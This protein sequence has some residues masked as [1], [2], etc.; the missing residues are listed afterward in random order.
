MTDLRRDFLRAV[1]EG[2]I[3]TVSDMLLKNLDPSFT[4]SDIEEGNVSHLYAAVGNNETEIVSLLLEHSANVNIENESGD[5]PLFLAL[6][7]DIDDEIL[8]LLL[9]YGAD[10]NHRNNAGHNALHKL[11]ED[12]TLIDEEV[13]VSKVNRLIAVINADEC[14]SVNAHGK[15]FLHFVDTIYKHEDATGIVS[16]RT[17]CRCHCSDFIQGLIAKGLSVNTKD[18]FGLTPLHSAIM[19]CCFEGVGTLLQN[20]AII[21]SDTSN[22]FLHY[23]NPLLPGFDQTLELLLS[24]GCDINERNARKETAL[25]AVLTTNTTSTRP[26]TILLQNGADVHAKDSLGETPLH[27]SVMSGTDD[28]LEPEIKNQ[29]EQESKR[30]DKLDKD[31]CCTET[32]R[33][34]VDKG[35]DVNNKNAFGLTALHYGVETRGVKVVES[36]IQLGADVN[37]RS[38]T[39]ETA[40]HRATK[41][42]ENLQAIFDI[43]KKSM[44]E[45]NAVDM[46][47]STPLH[48]AVWYQNAASFA[49][50]LQNGAE[51]DV[52]DCKGR[53]PLDL[54]Y[55]LR[56]ESLYTEVGIPSEI[57]D[58]TKEQTHSDH[59]YARIN[60]KENTE[61][62]DSDSEDESR[63]SLEDKNRGS[64]VCKFEDNMACTEKENIFGR[65]RLLL[66]I[67]SNHDEE[68]SLQ[69]WKSH[70]T[71]HKNSFRKYAEIILHSTEMGLYNSV[72]DNRDVAMEVEQVVSAVLERLATREPILESK[73]IL[74]GSRNEETKVGMPDEFDY[75]IQLQK[76]HN[77]FSPEESEHFPKGFIRMKM[78]TGH[79]P[80]LFARFIDNNGYLDGFK[81]TATLYKEFNDI[82]VELER[83]KRTKPYPVKFLDPSKGSIDNILLK[84]IGATYKNVEISVDIVPAIRQFNWVPEHLR[85]DTKLLTAMVSEPSYSVVLKTQSSDHVKNWSTYFRLSTAE[86]EATIIKSIPNPIRK[87]YILL[88]ALKDSSYFP[89]VVDQGDDD[90]VVSYITTYILKCAFLYE[91]EK[92]MTD[93]DNVLTTACSQEAGQSTYDRVT[94]EW[95]EKIIENMVDCIQKNDMPAYFAD[96]VNLLLDEGGRK[97]VNK[98][99]YK[100]QCL[101]LKHLVNLVIESYSWSTQGRNNGLSFDSTSSLIK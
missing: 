86:L 80:R 22:P 56:N 87:G 44:I 28:S 6:Y 18:I 34:L 94:I 39:G 5:T 95:A 61:L 42:I 59:C 82:L 15:T 73:L 55:L 31:S 53:T 67:Y 89:S 90:V 45:I 54:I 88:K 62:Q 93:T 58:A 7:E 11:F 1:T 98:Q 85:T 71:V 27:K 17:S 3:S 29:T 99:I 4:T 75:I 41:N 70:L 33:I 65:C 77:I 40:L 96:Q 32:I 9:K 60:D 38:K 64:R 10:A 97:I 20:R 46:Y 12:A 92:C 35:A 19:V 8:E 43:C 69:D 21:E 91:L 66:L 74:A 100:A 49:V 81:V 52:C 14:N 36:L 79:D 101:C 47:C 84:W 72:V 63:S 51:L 25:H 30:E 23:L 13:G 83:M 57:S 76:F 50:L 68:V 48:W 2:E 16:E 24:Y 37:V 26:L 78:K